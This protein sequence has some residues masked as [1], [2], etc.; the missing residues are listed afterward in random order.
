MTKREISKLFDDRNV[1]Y[2][3]IRK[4]SGISLSLTWWLYLRIARIHKPIG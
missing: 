4:R 1:P 2:G 3:T